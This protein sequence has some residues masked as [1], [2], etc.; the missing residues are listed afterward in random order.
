[1]ETSLY[2]TEKE[3]LIEYM[4]IMNARLKWNW[5]GYCCSVNAAFSLE[6]VVHKISQTDHL[7]TMT[8]TTQSSDE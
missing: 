4:F 7:K 3:L 2:C 8:I 1:M 5:K 6:H